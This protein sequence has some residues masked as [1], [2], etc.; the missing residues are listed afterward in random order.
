MST[1]DAPTILR[2]G[3]LPTGHPTPFRL[4]PGEDARA[5]LMEE[6]DLL[7]L[8]KVR[9]DGQ[10]VPEG[11][12]NW[13]LEGTLGATVVQPC[14]VTLVPVTTR[15]DVP[16]ERRYLADYSA[17][18]EVEAEMPEDDSIEP[19]P[20]S[21]DLNAVLTESLA[22]AIPDFPRAEGAELGEAVY[23]EPGVAPLRDQDVKPFAGLA[24]LKRKLES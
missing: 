10:M 24:D 22:L 2:L 19:L 12:R 16:V 3:R 11:R 9:F 6:L 4:E 8:R 7:D 5:K 21:I 15:I 1:S 13:R 23:A 20:E 18:A 17:P 14:S